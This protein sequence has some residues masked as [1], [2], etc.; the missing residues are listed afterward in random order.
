MLYQTKEIELPWSNFNAQLK[1]TWCHLNVLSLHVCPKEIRFRNVPP[2]GLTRT[3]KNIWGGELHNYKQLK[4][5][6]SNICSKALLLRA[7]QRSWLRLWIFWTHDLNWPLN[8][9][10][11][12]PKLSA[13]KTFIQRIVFKGRYWCRFLPCHLCEKIM[14]KLTA[15]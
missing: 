8:L 6:C 7:S 10:D 1:R 5:S 15:K 11:T 9:L 13:L 12:W 3:P 2:W 14:K 4:L